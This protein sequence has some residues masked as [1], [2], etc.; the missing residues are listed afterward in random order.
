VLAVGVALR[1]SEDFVA[2]VR[3]TRQALVNK[4]Y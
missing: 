2:S 3:K 4:R 1:R